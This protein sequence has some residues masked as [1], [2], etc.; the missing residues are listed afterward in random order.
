[1]PEGLIHR[2]HQKEHIDATDQDQQYCYVTDQEARGEYYS[3]TPDVLTKDDGGTNADERSRREVTNLQYEDQN[4]P[5]PYP[6]VRS[7]LQGINSAMGHN[8]HAGGAG[9]PRRASD[10]PGLP[11]EVHAQGGT[12]TTLQDRRAGAGR[13]APHL[14]GTSRSWRR[15]RR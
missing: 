7:A 1:M 6:E 12:G 14:P 15:T 13:Q 4:K 10:T 9:T 2:Y 5:I 11:T 8:G 3:S